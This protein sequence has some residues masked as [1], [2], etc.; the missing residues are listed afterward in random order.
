MQS[1]MA[2]QDYY[3]LL[4]VSKSASEKELKSAYRKMAM[5]YHPDRN[6][7]DAEAETKFKEANE[8]YEILSDPDKRAAYD[9]FGHAAFENGGMGGGPRGGAGA[10]GFEGFADIFEE[11]F[12]AFGGAGGGGRGRAPNRGATLEYPLEVSL[13]EAFKGVKK[14]ISFPVKQTCE[15][16]DGSGSKGNSEPETCPTCGGRGRVRQSQGFFAMERGCPTCQ[17]QGSIISDP[18]GD[19][20]GQGRTTREKKL[21]VTIPAGVQDGTT[22]QYP[23][24][25]EAGTRGG[26]PGDL[27]VVL[28]VRRHAIFERN[29]NDLH[30]ETP[31]S[32]VTAALGGKITVP[33]IDGRTL[34]ATIEPGTQ[35]GKTL[36]LRGQGMS[37]YN[38]NLRG[39]MIIHTAIEIPVQL[40]DKQKEILQDFEKASSEESHYPRVQGFL[41]RIKNLF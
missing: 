18:C 26:K 14:T 16:C 13:E 24:G 36:R 22:I 32:F 11:M 9:R 29:G 33:T 27:H 1:T 19:C 20:H 2:K 15:T 37:V 21:S 10:G 40:T 30:V 38:S 5:K 31:I 35:H 39:D 12:G 6:P 4:G 41:K 34:Q 17:G 23:G 28:G 7:D 8:A 3:D 25:G